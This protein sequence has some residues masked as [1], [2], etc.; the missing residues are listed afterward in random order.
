MKVRQWNRKPFPEKTFRNVC[1]AS[2]SGILLIRRKSQ[3]FRPNPTIST[4]RESNRIYFQTQKTGIFHNIHP[5]ENINPSKQ[6][7]KKL[8]AQVARTLGNGVYTAACVMMIGCLA[9]FIHES[10]ERL[11]SY[12]L[13]LRENLPLFKGGTKVSWTNRTS[14]IV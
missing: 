1:N 3:G 12:F 2:T 10:L 5:S 9:R 13:A 4:R 14:S 7:N 8:Q 6:H 11:V